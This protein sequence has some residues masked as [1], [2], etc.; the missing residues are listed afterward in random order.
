[1]SKIKR[2]AEGRE[3]TCGNWKCL[4]APNEVRA[5]IMGD[6]QDHD[7]GVIISGA[8]DA[9]SGLGSES[10]RNAI[11]ADVDTAVGKLAMDTCFYPKNR[12]NPH[13]KAFNCTCNNIELNAPIIFET[14]YQGR[15]HLLFGVKTYAVLLTGK[16]KNSLILSEAQ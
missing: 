6:N 1:M 15:G 13:L 11:S 4:Y 16:K 12:E 5:V 7:Y 10:V 2:P 3:I 8:V 9:R 14:V